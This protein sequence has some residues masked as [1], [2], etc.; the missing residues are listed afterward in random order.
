M[1]SLPWEPDRALTLETASALIRASFPSVD[2]TGLAYLGSG[3]EFDAYLTRDGWVFRFPR[4]AHC[5]VLFDAERRVYD[6][7]AG[8]LP[9][10]IAIPRVELVGSPALGF[11]YRFAGHRFIRGV[12]ADA[13]DPALLPTVARTLGAALGAI[14]SIPATTAHAAGVTEST[15]DAAELRQLFERVLQVATELRGLD[16]AVGEAARW[17][18]EQSLPPSPFDGDLRLIHQDLSPDHVIID[19][20]TGELVG[21]LD[22]TDTMLG[23]PARDFVF[24]VTW[25]GWEFAEDVFRSYPR[26]VDGAFRQ[27]LGFMARLL[28][29]MWLALAHEQKADLVTHVDG[30]RNAFATAS[31]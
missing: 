15:R 17:F 14:H 12:A 19:P 10:T 26:P 24:L 25:R 31:P 8:V 28:S 23:D 30:V 22:W 29:V 3:W 9:P 27:R 7:V 16:P 13:I 1:S 5:E 18:A 20:T 4:R 21:I 11:P 6:I 2:A